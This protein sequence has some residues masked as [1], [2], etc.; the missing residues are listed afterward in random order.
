MPLSSGPASG[1]TRHL[2]PSRDGGSRVPK[3]QFRLAAAFED[4]LGQLQEAYILA[5]LKWAI[6]RTV[7]AP[8]PRRISETRAKQ[9]QVNEFPSDI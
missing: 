4:A 2:R 7:W 1:S 9:C 6:A 5:T 8:K 3:N